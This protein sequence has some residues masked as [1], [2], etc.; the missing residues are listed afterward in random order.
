MADDSMGYL[1]AKII[2]I[3]VEGQRQGGRK[4]YK[5]SLC[6]NIKPWPTVHKAERH[7]ITHIPLAFRKMFQCPQCK[8]RFIKEKNVKRHL[9]S[10]LC[11]GPKE[12]PCTVCGEV[13][14]SK[15]DLQ[16]HEEV[17]EQ[18]LKRHRYCYNVRNYFMK[19]NR[20]F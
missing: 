14:Q 7:R 11:Q 18:L 5:C 10:G 6:P 16:L 13:F 2:T 4:M 15:F 1:E 8:E 20:I 9:D 12:H 19:C 3:R 17:H